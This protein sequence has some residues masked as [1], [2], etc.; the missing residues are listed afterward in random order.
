MAD[1][2]GGPDSSVKGSHGRVP[3]QKAS[4]LE[5]LLDDP[6]GFSFL[7]GVRLLRHAHGRRGT[8]GGEAFLREQL[9]VRPYL[10]LGFPPT[11]MVEIKELPPPDGGGHEGKDTLRRFQITATFLGLY[12]PS[13]PLPT[14]YTEEL[15]DEQNQ[16]K[17]VSRDFLDILNHVFF[18]LFALS[19][20]RYSLSHQICEESNEDV[21]TRLFSL[22]G[23]GSPD[24]L[25]DQ[26]YNQ[27]ALL[28][29]A[30]L[31]TQF[32]RSAAGLR[33]L[34]ADRTGFP[35][36]VTQC[37]PRR[38]AIP[39]DQ[40]CRLGRGV[41]SLGLDS[42]IGTRVAD[43]TGKIRITIGPLDADSFG[44]SHPGRP[45]YSEL[46]M[47]IRF[48]VTQPLEFDMEMVLSPWEA[49]PG[50][51]GEIRWSRLGCDVWL[52]SGPMSEARAV[53]RDCRRTWDLQNQR[54]K[55]K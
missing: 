50:R 52:S 30:G 54:S 15:L 4:L 41:N 20:G 33:G 43:G 3:G 46:L 21:L 1:T 31:L 7:Q 13:S 48:Y 38:A 45:A 6:R 24:M 2:P 19:D 49:Q 35:V 53:F 22:A 26:I 40:R 29:T 44:R 12:G 5:Q 11:D 14:F 17:S 10:S 27:G 51:L 18:T 34:L 32:P 16:D 55:E 47:M 8:K 25:G 28:R 37:V 36:R 39:R 42:R 23:L 9:R